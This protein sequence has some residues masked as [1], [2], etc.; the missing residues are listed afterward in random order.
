MFERRAR[1]ADPCDVA[2]ATTACM[3]GATPRLPVAYLLRSKREEFWKSKVY[4]EH[5]SPQQLWHSIDVLMGRGHAPTSF[6]V[7]ADKIHRF[8]DKKVAGTGTAG[9]TVFV[10]SAADQFAQGKHRVT[11]AI[12]S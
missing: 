5:S 2:V 6:A 12:S 10:G 9:Q 1:R 11:S 3:E 7:D 8:F 4:D